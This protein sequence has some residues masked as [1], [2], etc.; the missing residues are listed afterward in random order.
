MAVWLLVALT[1]AITAL[2]QL[3]AWNHLTFINTMI[4]IQSEISQYVLELCCLTIY[5]D[6]CP[7]KEKK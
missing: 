4:L 3:A 2:Q 6:T 7:Q 1:P 5:W